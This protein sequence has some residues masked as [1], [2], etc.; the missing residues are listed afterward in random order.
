MDER[1]LVRIA[2]LLHDIGKFSQRADVAENKKYSHLSDSDYGYTGAHAKWGAGYIEELGLGLDLEQLILYHHNPNNLKGKLKDLGILVQEADHLSSSERVK[3]EKKDPIK[4][5]LISI[6]SRL[7]INEEKEEKHYYYPLKSLK[8]DKIPYPE[9]YKKNAI[10]GWKLTPEYKV[11][12]TAYENKMNSFNNNFSIENLLFALEEFASFIPSAAYVS[13]PDVSLFDHSKTSCA[14]ASASYNYVNVGGAINSEKKWIFIGGN[15]S[16]IQKFIYNLKSSKNTLKILRGRSFYLEMIIE[17]ITNKILQDLNLCRANLIYSGGGNFFIIAQNTI[18][19]INKIEEIK[20]Q[21]NKSLFKKFGT[22]IYTL[23]DYVE[24]DKKDFQNF[25][26]V[27]SNL[28]GKISEGKSKKFL[29]EINENPEEILGP[30]PDKPDLEKCAICGH[31]QG[32]TEVNEED[33][34]IKIC[35]VCEDMVNIGTKIPKCDQFYIGTTD[36]IPL[37]LGFNLTFNKSRF[38]LSD[39]FVYNINSFY[40]N[41]TPQ[42]TILYPL[43]NY[44]AYDKDGPKTTDVFATDSIGIDRLATVRMDVD[45]LG[46]AFSKGLGKDSSLS[47]MSTLSRL[48]K[49]FF[50]PYMNVIAERNDDIKGIPNI[51]ENNDNRNIAIV[52][53]GG[54]DVFYI[55]SWNDSIEHAFEI[56]QSF[57]KYTCSNIGLSC[58]ISFN[59]EKYPIYKSAK[60]SEIAEALSKK[61]DRDSITLFGSTAKW[62]EFEELW[63]FFGEPLLNLT[64]F[65]KDENRR[66]S[67]I[68]T[69]FLYKLDYLR[70]A[71][72]KK[73]HI[74][75]TPFVY[76]LSRMRKREESRLEKGDKKKYFDKFY[77]NFIGKVEY[78]EKM[79]IPL[80]WIIYSMRKGDENVRP[81]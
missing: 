67:F 2:A 4:E 51:S 30:H 52:Y 44:Y 58:G 49:Y 71:Y 3:D 1:E 79:N 40:L 35:H 78:I 69:G 16:G 25:S 42:R 48:L 20:K 23:I 9:Q 7:K 11:L 36:G 74:M 75:M 43:G 6:F 41:E 21:A 39:G 73:G 66:E 59:K 53:S 57:D 70:R 10:D 47:R 33:I 17:S 31:G 38:N 37:T 60:D 12:W 29:D 65:N 68:S 34:N 81:K 54:D 62:K 18:D 45:R 56:R 50:G 64:T 76:N 55:G 15:I 32:E 24:I 77:D 14:I 26:E 27:W 63:S 46:L 8:F 72:S 80:F 5:P 19:A 13:L 61:N 22:K 28:L